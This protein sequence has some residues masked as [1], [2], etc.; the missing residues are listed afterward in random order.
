VEDPLV[1]AMMDRAKYR[2][3]AEFD[4]VW[5]RVLDPVAALEARPY[6]VTHF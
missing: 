2:V 1:W 3:T 5:V 4:E 6:G